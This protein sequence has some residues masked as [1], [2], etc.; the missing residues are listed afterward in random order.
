[1]DQFAPISRRLS[2]VRDAIGVVVRRLEAL[3]VS[4]EV[5]DLRLRAEEY[6]REVDG[7]RVLLPALEERERLMKLA[8]SLHVEVAR[9]EEEHGGC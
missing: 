3:P 8:L 4:P 6:L 9:L 7:W 2:L 5:E 1:M